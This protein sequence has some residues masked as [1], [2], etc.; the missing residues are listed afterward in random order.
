VATSKIDITASVP[1]LHPLV[2]AQTAAARFYIML[3][4]VHVVA[5]LSLLAT[6]MLLPI[7]QDEIKMLLRIGGGLIVA[8]G[9]FP[10]TKYLQ[11]KDRAFAL[12][13]ISLEYERMRV[14]G[15]LASPARKRLDTMI[16]SLVKGMMR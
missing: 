2:E 8:L 11:R 10:S 15:L 4:F 16:T 3:T 9:A 12:R 14:A 7:S 1:N 6:P 5:G 13:M